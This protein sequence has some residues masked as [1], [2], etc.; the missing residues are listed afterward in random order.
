MDLS[1]ILQLFTNMDAFLINL[2]SNY[3]LMIYVVMFLIFYLETGVFVFSFLPGDS[4]LFAAGVLAGAGLMGYFSAM[5]IFLLAGASGDCVNYILGHFAGPA[6]FRKEHRFIKKEYLVAAHAFYERHGGKAII[7]A[8]FIP[9]IR[10][11]APF[12]AGIARMHPYVFF[13][14]NII[15]CILWVGTLVSTGYFLGNLEFVRTHFSVIV[16][17]IVL[18]SVIPVFVSAVRARMM[19]G[20]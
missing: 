3:G 5:G 2:A 6:I 4:L 20:K 19:K 9:I 1:V 18:I 16:Y 13:F 15:G 11:F 17:A 14:Y 10:T 8:R 12:V 7:L